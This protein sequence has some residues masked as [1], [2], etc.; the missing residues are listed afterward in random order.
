MN[1]ADACFVYTEIKLMNF[2]WLNAV[3]VFTLF[4]SVLKLW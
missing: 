3:R 1:T 4:L 2:F